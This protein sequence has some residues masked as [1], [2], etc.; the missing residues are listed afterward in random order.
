MSN[1][2]RT[3]AMLLAVGMSVGASAVVH[4]QAYPVRPIHLVVG[5]AP[6]SVQD[7]AARVVSRRV[8]QLLGTQFVVE[9]KPGAATMIASESVAKARPDGYTLLQNGVAL[10]VNPG[11]YKQIPYDA[12][13]DFAPVAFLVTAPMI[14]V[15]QPSL[16]VRTLAEFLAKYRG[17][18]ILAY[19][20]PGAGTMPHLA[21]ELLKAKTGLKMR[22]V[23]YKGGA[24]ALND[25]I[26]GHVNLTFVTPV[27]KPQIDAGRVRAL[28]AAAHT[29]VETLPDI[30]TFAEA[31]LPLPEISAG[32]WFGILAPAGTTAEVIA[33]LNQAFNAALADSGTKE[34]LKRMGLVPNPMSPQE[35]AAFMRE[36]MSRWPAII[37]ATG[38]RG[39]E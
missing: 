32:A 23:P 39:E 29:R 15:V 38:V 6:G 3:V 10:S 25:V 26:A 19:A 35:F 20:S 16:E 37:A 7:A 5:V 9:N 4:A 28:A 34:E 24:L 13:R 8:G 14:L 21:A 11:L 31:G 30:P 36:D 27:A 33:R 17:T 12:A 22:N 1:V 2:T 18:D